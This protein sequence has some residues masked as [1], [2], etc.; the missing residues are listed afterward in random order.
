MTEADI[1]LE[2]ARVVTAA[3]TATLDLRLVGG[4]AIARRCPSAETRPQLVRHYRDI[5]L[6]ARPKSRGAVSD[7]LE[8]LGYEPD[9][10]FNSLHGHARLLFFDKQHERQVDVFLGIFR[11]CHTLDFSNCFLDGYDCLPLADL[12]L[13]KLQIVELNEKDTKDLVALFLD[14]DLAEPEAADIIDVS[15]IKS[16][17]CN[18]WGLYTTVKDNLERLATLCVEYLS[19]GEQTVVEDRLERVSGELDR[20]PKSLKWRLRGRLGR[21]AAWY[22]L[23]EEVSDAPA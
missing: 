1:K 9:Q 12:A 4:L 14:H 10:R 20:G 5:D 7:V 3:R 21:R 17:C 18:D 16:V 15:R 8:R 11:M 19:N 22:E 6:I 13:T 23:P 2:A